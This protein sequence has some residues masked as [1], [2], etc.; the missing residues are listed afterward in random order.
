M[1]LTHT[2]PSSVASPAFRRVGAALALA[3]MLT[4][5]GCA[6]D[7]NHPKQDAG[8]VI[9]GV[10]GAL[11]G[12]Q[13]GGGSGKLVGVGV[14]AVLGTMLGSQIG[15]SMD[16]ADQDHYRLA[17][18]QASSAPLNQPIQWNNPD[19]G[20]HGTV[21]AINDG[22]DAYGNYCRKYHSTVWIDNHP[23]ETTGT[24]CQQPDGTW[25]I[26]N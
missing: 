20:H 16:Q 25:K 13:F 21:T 2:S 23:Q 24:A 22:R 8:A 12:S 4:L 18:M 9:G 6:N 10:T 26:V 7:P 3:G 15:R 5:A 17:A 1:R 14:G 11:I 19:S